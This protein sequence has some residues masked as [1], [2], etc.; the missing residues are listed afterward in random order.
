M[1]TLL[2]FLL[3]GALFAQTLY[4]ADERPLNSTV[5]EVKVYRQ[6]AQLSSVAKTKVSKGD[7]LLV[8][9]A[10]SPYLVPHSVTASG[11]GAPGVIQS[12]KHR[13]SYL[14]T[15]PKTPRM[16]L[17]EDSAQYLRQEQ[18][19]LKD[20]LFVA[21]A[22][23]QLVL[24]NGSLS[25]AEDAVTTEELSK[26]AA[27]YRQRLAEIRTRMR[28]VRRKELHITRRLAQYDAE[29]Q[30]ISAQR[31]QPTQEVV[32]AFNA[33]REGELTLK[34]VYLV[35]NSGWNPYYDLRVANIS[36]PV[37]LFL[38]ANV[39]NNTGLDWKGVR[40]SLSTA[41][42][43]GSVDCP[44]LMP[45]YA[46]VPQTISEVAIG[47]SRSNTMRPPTPAAAG[48]DSRDM[49]E[50]SRSAA[51]MTVT[52]QGE[53]ALDFIIALPYDIPADG[54]E[55]QV[56]ILQQPLQGEFR[57]FAVP[58]L[59]R[60]AFLVM[61]I[62]QDLLRGPA[63]VYFEGAFVGQ[64]FINTDNPADSMR[65]SLGRDPKVLLQRVQAAEFSSR[66]VIGPNVTQRVAFDITVRNNKREA[67]SIQVE[68]QIPVSRDK[69]IRIDL[70][71]SSG[72]TLNAETGKLSWDLSLK[73][74]ETRKLRFA[75]EAKYP[76]DIPVSGL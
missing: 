76:K 63:N 2:P 52:E 27:F 30:Q 21:E 10:L 72:A 9:T 41:N 40:L 69:R 68:D 74:G 73:A 59:D 50:Q 29:Y 60:D 33:D 38:K 15:T 18:T 61:Y 5:E 44:M 62:R 28:D 58:K 67:V 51:E 71:E 49:R 23:E 42:N 16:R 65:I 26:M 37:L 66:Q 45:L 55:H 54:K 35:D 12:V 22:E 14:N 25:S 39:V 31:N 64:T 20:E 1:K 13:V 46:D 6:R 4:A 48:A 11:E 8:F 53:L 75:F 32:V 36:D 34:L 70:L 43:A 47:F 57:H 7:N 17:L 19:A 56:D 24:K 3:F